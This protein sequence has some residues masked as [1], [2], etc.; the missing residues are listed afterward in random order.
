MT[1]WGHQAGDIEEA[2]PLSSTSVPHFSMGPA[3][4]SF[5]PA[6]H[7]GLQDLGSES[8]PRSPSCPAEGSGPPCPHH[9]LPAPALT[10]LTALANLLFMQQVPGGRT[11]CFHPR[12]LPS[13]PGSTLPDTAPVCKAAV[14]S[15]GPSAQ[16]PWGGG[17]TLVPHSPSLP[18]PALRGSAAFEV[19][20]LGQ[21]EPVAVPKGQGAAWP[22]ARGE[23]GRADAGAWRS[24]RSQA[25]LRA[26][27]SR[28]T[29]G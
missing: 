7:L 26:F 24:H 18:P 2:F 23:S 29:A 13:H 20:P 28:P 14:R 4:A 25:L 8:A 6:S 21:G 27:L 9:M 22:A 1:G 15:P 3:A 16:G 12:P 10:F 19:S 11:A 17:S 5:P